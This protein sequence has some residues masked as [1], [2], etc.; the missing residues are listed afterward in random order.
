MGAGMIIALLIGTIVVMAGCLYAAMW[1][2]NVEGSFVATL[3]IVV[4][5][6]PLTQVPQVG[7]L[8]MI[9]MPGW[10]LSTAAMIFMLMKLT[11]AEF[12]DAIGVAL[13]TEVITGVVTFFIIV[14]VLTGLVGSMSSSEQ[15]SQKEFSEA[16]ISEYFENEGKTPNKTGKKEITKTEETFMGLHLGISRQQVQKVAKQGKHEMKLQ[17]KNEENT[18][19]RYTYAGN[20]RVGSAH[21]TTFA[22]HKGKL[23]SVTV[24][25]S[26]EDVDV[27]GMYKTIKSQTAEKYGQGREDA[28]ENGKTFTV[29]KGKLDV[30]LVLK[31]LTNAEF[32]KTS[33]RVFRF[34]EC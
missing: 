7:P 30:H 32:F 28:A 34:T 16:E 2:L 9:P 33:R 12:S 19:S 8:T 14:Q 17:K 11:D 13:L 20:F 26:G 10:F 6:A 22:Y 21:S 1:F 18:T 27:R 5:S 31:E 24:G 4:V 29:E 25:F 23:S 3:I 15:E